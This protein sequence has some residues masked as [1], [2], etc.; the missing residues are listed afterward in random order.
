MALKM[1]AHSR[2]SGKYRN[3]NQS[4]TRNKQ[5]FCLISTIIA[6]SLVM[7]VLA[8]GCSSSKTTSN[9]ASTTS[10]PA[11]TT[12]ST[13]ATAT[14]STPAVTTTVGAPTTTGGGQG[15]GTHTPTTTTT[16]AVLLKVTKAGATLKGFSLAEVDKMPTVN[17]AADG[18][19]YTGP[20]LA[21]LLTQAGVTSYSKLTIKGWVKGR[22]ATA[23]L[24]V[25]KDEVN[26]KLILRRTNSDT[27]SLAS[28]D[29][30][31]D[32]WIIDVN[33]LVVE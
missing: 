23:E 7:T 12:S 5:T 9:T 24:V 30:D 17:I 21:T 6:F 19:N 22:I 33:E 27:Y 13:P 1:M 25:T 29:I 15:T 18:K 31:A 26:D 28:P 8:T 16:A 3:T 32:S 14:N 10:A 11:V 20:T 4:R 2:A